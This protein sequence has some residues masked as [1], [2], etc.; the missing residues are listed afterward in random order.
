MDINNIYSIKET[1][2]ITRQNNTNLGNQG[3]QNFLEQC[4]GNLK[5]TETKQINSLPEVYPIPVLNFED[6]ESQ[7]L[8]NT[9]KVIN[10]LDKYTNGINN[11]QMSLKQIEPT[12]SELKKQTENLNKEAQNGNIDNSLKKIINNLNVL[13][14][15]EYIKFQRGDYI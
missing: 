3:F 1:E 8:N 12:I 5:G 6:T 11:P 14:N 15:V 4:T 13:A 2:R 10:I 9:Y 7:L